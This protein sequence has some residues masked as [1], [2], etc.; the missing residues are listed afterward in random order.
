MGWSAVFDPKPRSRSDCSSVIV[1]EGVISSSTKFLCDPWRQLRTTGRGS[2][3]IVSRSLDQTVV[4]E[5]TDLK[6]KRLIQWRQLRTAGRGVIW[7]ARMVQDFSGKGCPGVPVSVLNWALCSVLRGLVL[8][9]IA[10]GG[11]V[12]FYLRWCRV[13]WWCANR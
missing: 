7:V 9:S 8:G 10:G 2:Y 12:G 1:I 13:Q 6:R 3:R 4:L 11:L 5:N